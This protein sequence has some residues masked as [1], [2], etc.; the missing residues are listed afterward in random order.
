MATLTYV[1]SDSTAVIGPLSVHNE[2]H[3]YD[4]C[5]PHAQRLTAPR[6][7]EILR[8]EAPAPEPADLPAA[9]HGSLSRIGSAGSA[10]GAPSGENEGHGPDHEPDSETAPVVAPMAA[11]R[12]LE[13]APPP[14]AS[15]AGQEPAGSPE[16][17]APPAPGEDAGEAEEATEPGEP[18]DP[19]EAFEPEDD[20]NSLI[21]E[22]FGSASQ[23]PV[24]S[25]SDQPRA[26]RIPHLRR[27]PRR[28]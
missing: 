21:D 2:P 9:A 12:R 1:Y 24:S 16:V 26:M 18:E 4:L 27:R 14:A 17:E 3:A 11:V 22:I 23:E 5:A 28:Q 6:G 13:L 15:A 25:T 7:W 20:E 10:V 8:V 19:G